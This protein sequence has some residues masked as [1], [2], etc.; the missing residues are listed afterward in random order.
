M[1]S[2]LP[3]FLLFLLCVPTFAGS[4][5]ITVFAGD[6]SAKWQGLGE[7]ATTTAVVSPNGLAIDSSSHVL[8]ADGE[9]NQVFRVGMDGTIRVIAG[10]GYSGFS[11][12]GGPATEAFLTKPYS[13]VAKSSN[14]LLVSDQWNHRIREI[15][16]DGAIQTVVGNGQ[17]FFGLGSFSGDNG[18]ATKAGLNFPSGMS[19]GPEGSLYIADQMNARVRRVSLDGTITTYAGKDGTLQLPLKR[20]IDLRHDSHG[21]LLIVDAGTNQIY[22]A[23]QSG[24]VEILIGPPIS[25]TMK[26]KHPGIHLS[27]P[28]AVEVGPDDTLYWAENKNVRVCR[29]PPGQETAEVLMEGERP[30]V[31]RLRGKAKRKEENPP[32]LGRPSDLL[33]LPDGSL[34]VADPGNHKVWKISLPGKEKDPS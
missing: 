14:T 34:L 21:R 9:S 25:K 28:V 7:S 1:K 12:D 11:G 26:P 24:Q 5:T 17:G 13:V 2:R 10:C 27:F 3:L 23:S 22:S 6:G 30:S 18:P 16:P 20:P 33:L 15:Q 4:P 8:I 29:L 19:V 32:T 31:N